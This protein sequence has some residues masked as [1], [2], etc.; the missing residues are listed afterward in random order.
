[1]ALAWLE[2]VGTAVGG[3]VGAGDPDGPGDAESTGV[4]ESNGVGVG[5]GGIVIRGVAAGT[6]VGAGVGAG[7]ATGATTCTSIRKS[8][9]GTVDA[10]N[11]EMETSAAPYWERYVLASATDLPLIAAR[12]WSTSIV[13]D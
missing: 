10:Q 6:G 3:E 13:A 12:S 8:N 1:V 4:V 5:P 7:F 2:A 9:P 11:G